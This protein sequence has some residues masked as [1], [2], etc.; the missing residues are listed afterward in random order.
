MS[1]RVNLKGIIFKGCI[2]STVWWISIRK[3][4]EEWEKKQ[5]QIQSSWSGMAIPPTPLLDW[6]TPQKPSGKRWK[7]S[8]LYTSW[9]KAYPLPAPSPLPRATCLY[10]L[11]WGQKST[12]AIPAPCT[13]D[14][15][16]WVCGLWQR[17]CSGT[18][19]G[20]GNCS[21]ATLLLLYPTQLSP[22]LSQAARS[23]AC[24]PLNC[25]ES[26]SRQGSEHN[27]KRS[28]RRSTLKMHQEVP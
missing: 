7:S 13:M 2:D 22:A 11:A 4:M 8:L 24:P 6:S 25:G 17:A 20:W 27:W 28:L 3:R 23:G 9:S 21:P 12:R 18:R 19:Q 1:L 16:S 15:F 5:G 26:S 14:E 10:P